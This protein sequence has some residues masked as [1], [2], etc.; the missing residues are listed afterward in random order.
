MMGTKINIMVGIDFT[1]SNGDHTLLSSLH[2]ANTAIKN[3]YQRAIESLQEVLEKNIESPTYEAYGFGGVPDWLESKQVN[4]CFALNKNEENPSV[5]NF[6]DIVQK[7]L[8]VLSNIKLSG[9]SY[10]HN[11][12]QKAVDKA[13]PIIDG[14]LY[15]IV[16]LVTDGDIDDLPQTVELLQEASKYPISVIVVGVGDADFSNMNSLDSDTGLLRANKQ[17]DPT[18]RDLVQFVPYRQL[19]STPQILSDKILEELPEQ[20]ETYMR[21]AGIKPEFTP[22][23]LIKSLT[24]KHLKSLGGGL[25]S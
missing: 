21:N 16:I 19:M 18:M 22:E 7:Y 24:I 12:L 17:S 11:I 8:D 4:H 1:F 6:A 23:A 13:K 3:E 25:L 2:Y 10:F 5:N 20:F 9:P 15:T 14:K